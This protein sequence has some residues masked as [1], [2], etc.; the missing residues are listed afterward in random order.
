MNDRRDHAS[1][2]L[3]PIFHVLASSRW[4]RAAIIA[5]AVLL[6]ASEA[7]ALWDDKLELFIQETVTY[8]DNVFRL[9][10]GLNPVGQT[11]RSDTSF[12]TSPGFNL[13]IPW[14]RQRFVGGLRWNFTRYNTFKELDFDGQEARAAWLWQAGNDLS[15]QVGYTQTE[16]LASLANSR[17]GLLLGTPNSLDTWRAYVN[18]LYNVTPRWQV[19]GE[20]SRLEQENGLATQQFNNI[21]IDAAEA[22]LFYVTPLK[23]RVGIGV[24]LEEGDYP[25]RAGTGLFESYRQTIVDGIVDYGATARSRLIARAGV[26]SRSYDEAPQLDFTEGTYRLTWDWQAPGNFAMNTVLRREVAPLDDTYSTF[27][28]L[29]GILLNPTLR[30]TEKVNLGATLEWS[31]RDYLTEG[32]LVTDREDRV[33]TAIL[34]LSYRP[35]RAVTLDLSAMHQTRSADVA[36]DDYEVNVLS[37]GLRIGF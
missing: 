33:R 29:T 13:D 11:K 25:N 6:P 5:C 27:V 2:P 12:I 10:D 7:T 8:D 37:L 9:S 18:A 34:R 14:S 32:A 17:D 31:S 19:S 15:G 3:N 36:F 30:V 21:V 26:V 24:R 23:N 20:L 28:L 1:P 35:L 16:A 4:S 22:G